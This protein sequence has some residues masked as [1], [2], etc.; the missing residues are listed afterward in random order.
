M[1]IFSSLPVTGDINKATQLAQLYNRPMILVFTGSDWCEWSQKICD[2]LFESSEFSDSI[3]NAFI[4]VHLDFPGSIMK[5][6]LG[7]HTNMD[8]KKKYEVTSFPTLIMASPDGT[9]IT[10]LSYSEQSADKF[11]FSLKNIFSKFIHLQ[12]EVAKID[13]ASIQENDLRQLYNG[14]VEIRC[15]TFISH[16][17]DQGMKLKQGAFFPVE[18]YSQLVLEGKVDTQEAKDL[19]ELVVERDFDNKEGARLRLALLDFQSHHSDPDL[20]TKEPLSYI[21]DFGSNEDDN[22]W[23]LHM[24]ISDYFSEHGREDE[25][26]V[27]AIKSLEKAPQKVKPLIQIID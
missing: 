14:A 19:K 3:G 1:L 24:L 16:L 25:A 22:L 13:L 7:S 26:K 4:F 15:P 27:H 12:D 11:A 18:K 2:E 17:L 9:E 10:R 6:T 21:A 23:R 8:L 5:Q 20:A